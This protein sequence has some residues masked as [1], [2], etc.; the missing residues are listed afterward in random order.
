M[1]S[2]VEVIFLG[3]N[4]AGMRIYDWLCDQDNIFMHSIL[5]TKDQLRIIKNVEP[6]YIVSCGYQHIVPESVLTIPTK[7]CLNLHPAYLP[8]NRGANPN[9]WSIIE[10]TPAGVTLHYMDPGIDTGD[11]VARRKVETAF[12]DSGKDLHK[13]LEDAQLELFQDVWSD[14]LS[15]N[16]SVVE[17]DENQG[18][19]HQTSEFETLCE[20][21]P[22]EEVRVKEFLDR[23]RALTFPPYNNAKI[24]ID[25]ETYYVEVD[26][27]RK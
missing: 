5:T 8:Y 4:D 23:L 19:Y 27:T 18:T 13:R 12:S 14:I 17:Q 15:D 21:N 3:I 9:V 10:G 6:D 24:E 26:I 25:D 20:L 2:D 1:L 16:I 7:G 22:D 11:I